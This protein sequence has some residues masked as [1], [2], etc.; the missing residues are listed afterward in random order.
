[1]RFTVRGSDPGSHCLTR[2]P[3]RRSKVLVVSPPV[4]EEPITP[5]LQDRQSSELMMD[6]D[7][8]ALSFSYRAA[9]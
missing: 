1:M 4:S 7:V 8:G 5:R 9:L 3:Q 2:G 6:E